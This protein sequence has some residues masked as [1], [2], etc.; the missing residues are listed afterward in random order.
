VR[1]SARYLP[2]F[3]CMVDTSRSTALADA[4]SV[5]GLGRVEILQKEFAT[6][7]TCTPRRSC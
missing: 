1:Q 7:G 5:A 2:D 4:A 3:I 6:F